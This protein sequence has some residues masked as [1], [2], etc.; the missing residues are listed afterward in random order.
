MVWATAEDV[1]ALTGVVL[2][3]EEGETPA[4][5]I[6]AEAVISLKLGVIPG[7]APRIGG[8]DGHFIRSAVAYQAAW[9]RDQPDLFTRLDVD[10]LSQDGQSVTPRGDGLVLAPLAKLALRRVSWR[11]PSR[12]ITAS[13]S[14]RVSG[15]D[16]EDYLPNGEPVGWRPM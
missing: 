2:T 10:A 1:K 7:E 8:R 15:S 13:T 16:L 11:A 4:E 6:Q 3:S 14:G 9:L 5:L 12:S